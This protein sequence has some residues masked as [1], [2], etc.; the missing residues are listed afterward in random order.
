MLQAF[1]HKIHQVKSISTTS[2]IVKL[3]KSLEP[4]YAQFLA[5]NLPIQVQDELTENSIV[6]QPI[7][8]SPIFFIS[9]IDT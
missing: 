1:L 5:L 4:K 6:V 3:Q 9:Q 8:R 7:I 2:F